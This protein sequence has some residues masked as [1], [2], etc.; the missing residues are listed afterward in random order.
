M[1][2]RCKIYDGI[3][4]VLFKELYKPP[5]WVPRADGGRWEPGAGKDAAT[6]T[7]VKENKLAA[8]K[9]AAA[10]KAT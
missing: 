9:M 8:E 10:L 3:K 6:A 1:T 2:F 7:T 5:S 4:V